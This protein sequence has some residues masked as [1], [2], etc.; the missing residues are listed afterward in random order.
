MAAVEAVLASAVFVTER[1]T[2]ELRTTVTIATS[3][4]SDL[5]SLQDTIDSRPAELRAS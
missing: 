3:S 4:F 2:S 5:V 1:G